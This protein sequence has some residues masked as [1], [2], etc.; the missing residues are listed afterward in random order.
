MDESGILNLVNVELVSEKSS[1]AP[2]EE[3]STFSILGSTIS[4]LFAGLR[5]MHCKKCYY[6]LIYNNCY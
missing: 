2:D 4:K 6:L 5:R 1:L 3:E